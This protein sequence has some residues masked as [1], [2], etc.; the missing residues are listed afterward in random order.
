M[1][2]NRRIVLNI[3]A[4]YGRSLFALVCGLFTGRWVLLSL[5]E[6]DYGLYGLVAGLTGFISFFN[7][8]LGSAIARFYAISVGAARVADDKNAAMEECRAWFNT[9]ISVHTIVPILLMSVGY[10]IGC[11]AISHYLTIPSDRITD[12]IW[13]FRFVCLTCFLSMVSIPFNAM[14]TA[15]QYIAEL[16]IYSFVTTTINIVFLYY[17]ISHPGK[18]LVKYGLWNC[19]MVILPN[20]IILVRAIK[21]FPECHLDCSQLFRMQRIKRLGGFACWQIIG[22]ASYLLRTQGMAVLLN[23]FFGPRV[24]A[25]M[26]IGN[27]VNGHANTLS[28]SMMGALSPAIVNAY[29]ACDFKRMRSLVFTM[30]RFGVV[31][32]MIFAVPLIM[33]MSTILKIWLKQPPQYAAE[34]AMLFLIQLLIENMTVGHMI[35]VNATGRIALY[36]VMMG[37]LSLM[38]LPLAYVWIRLGGSPCVSILSI[39]VT[40]VA[41]TIMRLWFSRKLVDLSVRQWVCQVGCPLSAVIILSMV[42]GRVPSFFMASGFPRVCVTTFFCEA[43]L[44]PLIWLAILSKEERNFVAQRFGQGVRRIIGS[45]TK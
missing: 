22:S 44:L 9:A 32:S 18:W 23:K 12:C 39:I 16:T 19:I 25:A 6:V 41:Y 3:C 4:T 15:K 34:F 21:I 33:E 8:V 30:C 42:C 17:M 26:T 10:P 36:Q 24:N 11:W 31:L 13:V 2:E 29:G 38:A 27:T 45:G 40:V 7:G 1:T 35:A 37:L 20:V 14:Y 28:G 5:G 43:A